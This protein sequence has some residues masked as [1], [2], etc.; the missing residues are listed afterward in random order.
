ME[1]I[2]TALEKF[3]YEVIGQ[4]LPGAFLLV[5]LYFILPSEVT[6]NYVPETD[7]G[8][9]LFVAAAYCFGAAVSSIGSYFI[10]PL[11]LHIVKPIVH[12]LPG[13]RIKEILVSNQ[14]LKDRHRKSD[15]FKIIS[16]HFED[17]SS[18]DAIRNISMSCID[19]AHR[20]TTVRFMF[21]SL[22][23]QGVAT[24]VMILSITL[25][26][27]VFFNEQ[28]FWYER[29]GVFF[30]VL[31][32]GALVA[33]PFIL[34]ER[35]FYERSRRLPL[36]CYLA[37]LKPTENSFEDSVPSKKSVYLSG[38]HRS[39]WQEVLINDIERFDFIN[40]SK[41]GLSDARLYKSWDL[42]SVRNCEIIFAYFEAT[43]PSGYGLALEVGYGAALG[44]HIIMV[45]EKSKKDEGLANY[46]KIVREASDVVFD[47]LED[48]VDYLKSLP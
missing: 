30:L 27:F 20:E 3:F 38:G 47:S 40:P 14:D 21:L 18:L 12:A 8:I 23:S 41:N 29:A 9:W 22:L 34:R 43:N 13:S 24:S 37:Q 42:Y 48:G 39:G 19:S 5:G 35:E 6:S 11:Y 10:I 25:S 45:D 7:F 28:L 31:I 46:L 32:L 36:D 17:V 2:I 16:R 44:K 26:V 4:L 33:L 15:A 1:N